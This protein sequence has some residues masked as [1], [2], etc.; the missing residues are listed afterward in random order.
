MMFRNS[1]LMGSE[2]NIKE[3]HSKFREI[4]HYY[5]FC[6]TVY[7]ARILHEKDKVQS[8]CVSRANAFPEG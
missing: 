3:L 2:Q 4:C 5:C 8:R 6:A 1:V 7:N